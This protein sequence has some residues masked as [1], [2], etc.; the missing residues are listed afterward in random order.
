MTIAGYSYDSDVYCIKCTRVFYNIG[1]LTTED[2]D[3]LD[4]NGLPTTMRDQ[5]GNPVS[6]MFDGSEWDWQPTC[7]SCW[8]EL[9]VS[10]LPC[11]S[12]DKLENLLEKYA[13]SSWSDDE[14]EMLLAD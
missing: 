9:D 12:L 10:I 6:V 8:E 7:G 4:E 5:E 14:L 1:N 13:E 3:D 2:P 11:Y